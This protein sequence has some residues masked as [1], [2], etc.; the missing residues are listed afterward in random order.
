MGLIEVWLGPAGCGKT[1]R[2][3]RLL[4]EE[5]A[6]DWRAARYLVPTV[7]HKRCLEQLLLAQGARHGL[8]GD[9]VNIFF[10]F[11]RETAERARLRVNPLT[12]L[13]KP[14]VLQHLIGQTPL[15]VYDRAA[16]YPG[17]AVA[18][19]DAIDEL[20]VH[21]VEPGTV[22]TAADEAIARG[23]SAFGAKLREIGVL[24]RA[25]QGWVSERDLFDNEGMMWVAAHLLRQQPEIFAE[26]RCLILDGFARLTPIQ[27][28]F[29]GALAGVVGR[30]IVLFD[31]EEGRSAAYHPVEQS[32][33][34]LEALCR[35]DGITLER[36]PVC[37]ALAPP[38]TALAAARHELFRDRKRT[39]ACDP[40]LSLLTGATPAHEAVLIAR[41][42]RAVLRAGKL[43][44]G[45]PVTPGEIAILARNASEVRDRLA[46]TFRQYGLSIQQDPPPLAHTALGRA[47]LAVFRLV[48]NRWKREDVLTLLKSGFLELPPGVA[49]QID[50]VA[51][52]H[53]LRDRRSSWSERWPDEET[54]EA[55]RTA[56][57]PLFAFDDAYHR[58]RGELG[59]M[60]DALATLT[61]NFA[62]QALSA[63]PPLPDVLPY[64]AERRVAMTAAFRAMASVGDDLRRLETLIGANPRADALDLVADALARESLPLPTTL[65]DGIPVLDVHATG[66]TKYT[67]V[68]LCG[69]LQGAFPRR[70]RESA[71]LMDHEREETLR[72]LNV[73]IQ[74][75]KGLEDDERYWFLHGLGTATQRVVL[76][77]A[78]HD[79]AGN[80]LERS[81]FLDELATLLPDLHNPHNDPVFSDVMPALEHAE[82]EDEYLAALALALRTAR[83][84]ERQQDIT[85]AYAACPA[86]RGPQSRL[87]RLFTRAHRPAACLTT[88][89]IHAHFA[90]RSRPLSASELQTY[91]DCPFLWYAG[92]C[93]RVSPIDEE[94]NALDRGVILHTVLERFYR[95]RQEEPGT[96][97]S[98][99]G[100]DVETVW[101]EV[102]DDLHALLMEEPRH[103]NRRQ[104]LQDLEEETLT[105]MLKRFLRREIDQAT[106]YR[107]HPA[108][109]EYRFGG[110]RAP[111]SLGAGIALRGTIDRIDLADDDPRR[112]LL[113]DYKSSVTN[114][115]SAA[116]KQ[117]DNLQAAVYALALEHVLQCDPL[118][119]IFMGLR[120][121]KDKGLFHESVKGLGRAPHYTMT[122]DDDDWTAFRAACADRITTTAHGIRAGRIALEP[123]TKRCPKE[124]DYCVLC[125]GDRFQLASRQ[126]GED[127]E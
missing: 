20:K 112:A 81:Q 97:V 12:D 63:E 10:T 114:L 75:R 73:H 69:L 9:P 23:H 8:F 11:A 104:F 60:L 108:F 52:R 16:R 87:A 1:G 122:L 89:A 6:C 102:A 31:Y 125:R 3:L 13:Q 86:A 98:L 40:S 54:A 15:E 24:Y 39:I 124:C 96:P 123:T 101:P 121:G 58:H 92:N 90:A 65:H 120:D 76:S 38:P 7:G 82:S 100:V 37:A 46:R 111:L 83:D 91:L 5:M 50:L 55:L 19:H 62:A 113:I 88:P 49:L 103:R 22:L 44:D 119:V 35:R 117:G 4:R 33:E 34:Q 99:A 77:Y 78:Q 85:A 126:R 45:T 127:A 27:V 2:A 94:F 51:R 79:T 71:F 36:V 118:G 47:V 28:D 67:L 14:F 29:L 17:F 42:V 32:L 115:T 57:T 68:Y 110:E 30:I 93:L 53:Y 107:H 59:A 56:L 72:D 61:A 80:P 18:L 74:A 70:V 25:Y 26:L 116:L 106:T 48:R 43:P 84:P 66:G 64:Q 21:M 95:R 105:R 109:F 41:D